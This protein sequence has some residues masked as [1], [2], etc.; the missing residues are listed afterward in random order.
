MVP[1]ITLPFLSA[2][3]LPEQ[4]TKP[5]AFIAWDYVCS[6]WKISTCIR[7]MPQERGLTYGPAAFQ[8]I[9]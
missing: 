6:Q 8:L 3:M 4:K 1:E 9:P 2:G 7:G 5:L